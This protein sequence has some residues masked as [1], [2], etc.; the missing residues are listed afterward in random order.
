MVA[1]VTRGVEAMGATEVARNGGMTPYKIHKR[2]H[3]VT[4]M[5]MR[6]NTSSPLYG[7]IKGVS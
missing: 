2:Y 3:L 4:N 7:S 1:D 6:K 5:M